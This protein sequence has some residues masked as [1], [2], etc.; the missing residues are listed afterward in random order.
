MLLVKGEEQKQRRRQGI[1]FLILAVIAA[2]MATLYFP[3]DRISTSIPAVATLIASIQFI[4]RFVG[5]ASVLAAVV[6][7]YGLLLLCEKEGKNIG[8]IVI[9]TLAVVAVIQAMDYSQ[10]ILFYMQPYSITENTFVTENN[11]GYASKG[12]YILCD[13]RYEVVT[14]IFEPRSFGDVQ[15][16]AYEKNGTSIVFSV[17]SAGSEGYVL[18][19]L[20]N[21]KGYSVSSADGR[22][23]NHNLQMGENAVV[24][25]NIPENYAGTISVRYQGFWYWRVAELLSLAGILFLADIYRK[26]MQ[27]R[28]RVGEYDA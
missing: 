24:R 26:E 10:M 15:V 21:Y 5:A 14:E 23:T 8:T 12:E 17:E 9:A 22:I 3:W 2:W 28:K 11:S 16:T 27:E 19:P 6:T 13:A 7:G 20:L 1:C 25:V 18:L 4:W